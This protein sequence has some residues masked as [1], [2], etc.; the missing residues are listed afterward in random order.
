MA[1]RVKGGASRSFYPWRESAFLLSIQAVSKE[2]LKLRMYFSPVSAPARP[3]L[4]G[5]V[6]LSK[7]EHFKQ[8]VIVRENSLILRHFPQLPVEIFYWI[9]D[10]NQRSDRLRI[11]EICG[12]FRSVRAPGLRYFRIF[13][14]PFLAELFKLIKGGGLRKSLSGVIGFLWS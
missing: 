5:Y 7:I 13:W 8:S 14:I 10:A 3:P 1:G 6:R 9:C 12:Q 2:N 4:A 11:L